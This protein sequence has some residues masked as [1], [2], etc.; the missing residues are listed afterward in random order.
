[1]ES[2]LLVVAAGTATSVAVAT[3]L[4]LVGLTFHS[5]ARNRNSASGQSERRLGMRAQD[6]LCLMH[7]ERCLRVR[8]VV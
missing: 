6:R 5:G 7:A 3:G 4:L 1:M 8:V 2:V